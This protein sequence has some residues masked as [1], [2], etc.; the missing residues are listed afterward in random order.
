MYRGSNRGSEMS[1]MHKEHLK[2]V[3]PD[4]QNIVHVTDKQNPGK[5]SIVFQAIDKNPDKVNP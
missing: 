1:K 5:Q 2:E 4:P 3:V